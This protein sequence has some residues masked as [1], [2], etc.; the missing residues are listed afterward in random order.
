MMPRLR[1]LYVLTALI[2]SLSTFAGCARRVAPPEPPNVI[3]RAD[4]AF[5]REDYVTAIH[6]YRTYL[7]ALDQGVHTP[8]AFYKSALA[9]Y[10][11]NRYGEAIATLDELAKRYP[12][13][14][15]VQVDALRGDC[16]RELG[17]S[18]P[19]LSAWDSAWEEATDNDK[20]KLRV[21][22]S[23]LLQ[24]MPAAELIEANQAVH[25]DEIAEMVNQEMSRRSL[26][27]PP[28]VIA[29]R[30]STLEPELEP[31]QQP[32]DTLVGA[33]QR[34]N[35]EPAAEA[36]EESA[37]PVAVERDES[38]LEPADTMV[39]AIQRMG[40]HPAPP[41]AGAPAEAR[42]L[43]AAPAEPEVAVAERPHEPAPELQPLPS[44][45]AEPAPDEVAA[46]AEPQ[47]A[48]ARNAEVAP[49]DEDLAAE[50]PAVP[51]AA[52]GAR[53]VAIQRIDENGQPMAAAPIYRPDP[54]TDLPVEDERPVASGGD[55]AAQQHAPAALDE[56]AKLDAGEDFSMELRGQPRP[57]DGFAVRSAAEPVDLEPADPLPPEGPQVACILPL[58]GKDRDLGEHVLRGL[59]I[60]FGDTSERLVI[61]DSGSNPA[62]AERLL[63]QAANDDDI[64]LAIA[65]APAG[66]AKG[67]A[68]LAN[69]NQ[70]PVLLLSDESGLGG[71]F[72]TPIHSDAGLPREQLVRALLDQAVAQD[73]KQYGIVYPNDA[74]GLAWVKLFRA[75]LARR[76]GKVVASQDYDT[77]AP[78]LSP[79]AIDDWSERGVDAIFVPDDA[80]KAAAFARSIQRRAPQIAIIGVHVW[81]DSSQASYN[82]II[83]AGSSSGTPKH[84]SFVE[85]YQSVYGVA[86]NMRDAQAYDAGVIAKALL[87]KNVSARTA[88]AS[89]LDGLGSLEGAVSD[90]NVSRQGV[91]HRVLLLRSSSSRPDSPAPL[92]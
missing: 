77:V 47:M 24:E 1:T 33:I 67:L 73:L 25:H 70:L 46:K 55:T 52:R 31:G 10:R 37:A 21:R 63:R 57:S 89:G 80:A 9:S 39:G 20:P 38:E 35:T 26:V 30:G 23:G 88:V 79:S 27:A 59:R 86:P 72:V 4:D 15:W 28:V 51:A 3:R 91:R 54:E 48:E 41:P 12:K 16:E 83:F 71:E 50:P 68:Q 49:S 65:G 85:R 6:E 84:I 2:F 5:A 29:K 13:A 7:D 87:R 75:E 66:E 32:P 19:A 76:G 61:K 82:G 74:E 45:V 53:P 56:L 22:I 43:E 92:G 44:P 90:L 64:L 18:L 60:V 81:D 78:G 8:R 34:W 42:A 36:D 69:Q 14:H 11:L 62:V 58:S 17:R 40:S